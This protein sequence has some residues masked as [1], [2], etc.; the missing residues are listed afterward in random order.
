V[1]DRDEHNQSEH[2]SHEEEEIESG[3][4]LLAISLQAMKGTEQ[5]GTNLSD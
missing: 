4:E 3:E 5:K 1:P 2:H